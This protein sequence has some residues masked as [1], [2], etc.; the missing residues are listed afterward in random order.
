LAKATLKTV[1]CKVKVQNDLS[2]SQEMH[3]G[4]WQADSLACLL[5]T[6][7]LEKVLRDAE[8]ETKGTIYNKSIQILTCVVDIDIICWTVSSVKEAFFA[9]S[10]A[11]NTMGLTYM[12]R[13]WSYASN[14]KT[15]NI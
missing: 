6:I 12:K 2:E 10:I 15:C 5:F 11:A 1:K 8:L 9:L 4:L 13:K 14:Q 7:A 3:T